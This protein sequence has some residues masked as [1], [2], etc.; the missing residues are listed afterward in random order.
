MKLGE[1]GRAVLT[2]TD[3]DTVTCMFAG[4]EGETVIPES[5]NASLMVMLSGSASTDITCV[6]TT[7]DITATGE[8]VLLVRVLLVSGCY[9]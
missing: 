6:L 8:C 7:M 4:E 1:P 9:W 5:V 2:I 3:E